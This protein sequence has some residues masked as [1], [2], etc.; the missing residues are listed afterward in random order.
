MASSWIRL[1]LIFL[2]SLGA[3]GLHT[4]FFYVSYLQ[5]Q[6]FSHYGTISVQATVS[7]GPEGLFGPH[8]LLSAFRIH[9][10][11]FEHAIQEA[12][13]NPTDSTVLARLGDDLD[14]FANLV[15]EVSLIHA[16]CYSRVLRITHI[17]LLC[18]TQMFLKP[19]SY[20]LFAT[21]LV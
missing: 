19:Q 17:S 9:Y 4:T 14:E 12:S 10:R 16:M 7:H 11:R 13:V 21:I 5:I 18:R 6:A 3:S 2:S 1:L 15:I 20:Q 8:D